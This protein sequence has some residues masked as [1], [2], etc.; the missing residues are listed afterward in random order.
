VI[1]TAGT[2]HYAPL[3]HTT[4]TDLAHVTRPKVQAAQHLHELTRD[5]P[6]TAFVL[7]SSGAG[8]WGGGDQGGYAA[9]NAYLDALAHHRRATGLP[10]TSLAWGAWADT[11]MAAEETSTRQLNRR[12]VRAMNPQLAITALQQ[13]LDHDE[14]FL[15]I[16]HMDWERFTET[17]TSIR[18]SPLITDIPEVIATTKTTNPHTPTDKQSEAPARLRHKLAGMAASEQ[19]ET[20]L[21]LVR[22]HAAVALGH[23]SYEA[24][25]PSVGFMEAG[26]DSLTVLELCKRMAGETGLRLPA[27]LLFDHS[28]PRAFARHLQAVLDVS[29]AVADPD[30][31]GAAGGATGPVRGA[32]ANLSAGASPSESAEILPHS[33]ASLFR[34]AHDLDEVPRGMQLMRAASYFRPGFASVADMGPAPSPLRL[35]RGA[36]QPSLLCLPTV[37]AVASPNQ[38][39]RFASYFRGVRDMWFLPLPGF[40][41]EES[42]PASMEALMEFESKLAL[43]CVGDTP[44]VL[45]GHS[46]GGLVAHALAVHLEA[47]GRPPAALVLI[48]TYAYGS[49]SM[50]TLARELANG[51]FETERIFGLRMDDTRL[52]AMGCY[53]RLFANHVPQ[54]TSMP[55]LCLRGVDRVADDM[56]EVSSQEEWRPMWEFPHTPMDVAGDHFTI[57]QEHAFATAESVDC[58]L[59]STF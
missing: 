17:F 37:A 20:L 23:A 38:Y 51:M 53:L 2:A 31:E 4:L 18:H 15:T 32:G 14:T 35:A 9:A 41:A 11:G 13:A 25:N 55:T 47:I 52:T 5:L 36:V 28:T 49:A 19:T 8:V 1:H 33:L 21:H 34:R 6:L 46:G 22:T 48:D 26:F 24:I 12:G 3:T 59:D 58:W 43:D 56:S 7:F 27:T 30:G 42:T 40:A 29:G 39:A 57:M 45:V 16:T 50:V 10:A 44:F 54:A